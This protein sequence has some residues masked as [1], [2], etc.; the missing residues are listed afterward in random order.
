MLYRVRADSKNIFHWLDQKDSITLFNFTIRSKH[1]NRHR[2]IQPNKLSG[3]F[4]RFE[5]Y[6]W[7]FNRC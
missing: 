7:D 6:W 4:I 5:N 2:T 3:C 1:E